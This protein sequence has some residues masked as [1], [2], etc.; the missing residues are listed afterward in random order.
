MTRAAAYPSLILSLSKRRADGAAWVCN[1]MAREVV[2]LDDPIADV[3]LILRRHRREG[4]QTALDVALQRT[5]VRSRRY[6]DRYRFPKDCGALPNRT[7]KVLSEMMHDSRARFLGVRVYAVLDATDESKWKSPLEPTPIGKLLADT[8]K[9]I[10][11]VWEAGSRN[12][13]H[14]VLLV[15][16]PKKDD[17]P[18]QWQTVVQDFTAPHSFACVFFTPHAESRILHE[19]ELRMQCL[20]ALRLLV[21][22]DFQ[23]RDNRDRLLPGNRQACSWQLHVMR[24]GL[25]PIRQRLKSTVALHQV[26]LLRT[27]PLTAEKRASLTENI[28][29]KE[30]VERWTN[31]TRNAPKNVGDTDPDPDTNT[32]KDKYSES[33]EQYRMVAKWIEEEVDKIGEFEAKRQRKTIEVAGIDVDTANWVNEVFR[34]LDTGLSRRLAGVGSKTVIPP[35]SARGDLHHDADGL[36][37]NQL[38]LLSLAAPDKSTVTDF[39]AFHSDEGKVVGVERVIALVKGEGNEQGIQ[40]QVEA[41]RN[42][43][44]KRNEKRASI[45][46]ERYGGPTNVE[47]QSAQKPTNSRVAL[48]LNLERKRRAALRVLAE[49]PDPT[50]FARV[51]YPI[52]AL[53]GLL[54]AFPMSDVFNLMNSTPFPAN[55][56]AG[57]MQLWFWFL[58]L[59]WAVQELVR[60]GFSSP[61]SFAVFPILTALISLAVM[62]V[63]GK[64]VER[65]IQDHI[66]PGGRLERAVVYTARHLAPP[67]RATSYLLGARLDFERRIEQEVGGVVDRYIRHLKLYESRLRY[68][69]KRL[70]WLENIGLSQGRE[71]RREHGTASQLDLE[72][73]SVL[74]PIFRPNGVDDN[75][76]MLLQ[77]PEN[78]MCMN[79]Y[80]PWKSVHS[81]I[82]VNVPLRFWTKEWSPADPQAVDRNLL[83]PQEFLQKIVLKPQE[84]LLHGDDKTRRELKYLGDEFGRKQTT[85]DSSEQFVICKE[86]GHLATTL[87]L[88]SLPEKHERSYWKAKG[89]P[90]RTDVIQIEIDDPQAFMLLVKG[91]SIGGKES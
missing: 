34:K 75:C 33:L 58:C 69:K 19:N 7:R 64:R 63:I 29:V 1:E 66:G 13:V 70:D 53:V 25:N 3:G 44:T 56:G 47:E 17:A 26:A 46:D 8:V 71:Q 31:R 78:A 83:F 4:A 74:I 14:L 91:T 5:S 28:E 32:D 67:N 15:I 73:P 87:Q 27:A 50:A 57:P 59:F 37:K 43:F 60:L 10:Q 82:R 80:P 11:T 38:P 12:Q 54:L 23:G 49:K 40:D 90:R 72:K 55:P 42:Q 2:S 39:S 76:W 77:D 86:G 65:R 79:L 45:L 41:A 51:I 30:F 62:T 22:E 84:V 88:L 48:T 18:Q 61:A 52:A 35:W 36:N 16:A 6:V 20:E 21:L 85:T 24:D 68:T 89:T 81:E 9:E